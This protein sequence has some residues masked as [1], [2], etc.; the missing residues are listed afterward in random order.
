MTYK[1]EKKLI[2]LLKYSPLIFIFLIFIT[3]S[4]F[5]YSQNKKNFEDDK[6]VLEEN[7]INSNKKNIKNDV[8][9]IHSYINK[10]QKETENELKINLQQRVY[11]AYNIALSI[12]NLNKKRPKEEIKKMIKDA[13]V[14]IRFLDGRGYFYIYSF[15][16]ECILLPVNRSMEGSNFYY[17]KEGKGKYLT[18]EIIKSLQNKKESFLKWWYHKPNDMKNQYEKIGFNKSFE[19]F[20]WYIGT[21]EYIDDFE[22]KQQNKVLDYI[23]KL[24]YKKDYI[25]VIN[26][27]AHYLSHP[28]KKYINKD[29]KTVNNVEKDSID[30]II[31]EAKKS[32]KG[33]ITYKQ[34]I[35]FDNKK[36]LTKTSYFE[37]IPKWDWIIGKGFYRS[38]IEKQ[39]KIRKDFLDDQFNENIQT[40]FV[41]LFFIMLI[42]LGLSLYLSKHFE[43][44]FKKYKNSI[45]KYINEK[46]KQQKNIAFQA[47]TTALAEMLVNI[48]HQWRQ[49]LSIISTIST[50]MQVQKQLDC[51][52]D[53]DLIRNLDT[54]NNT[55]QQLSKTI[56]EFNTLFKSQDIIST[57]SSNE[58]LEKCF[59]IVKFDKQI[60][61]KTSID[62][63]TLS[64]YKSDLIQVL[65]NIFRNSK[66][67]F[68]ES[69]I[70]NKILDIKM[71]NKDENLEITIVDNALGIS[72]KTLSRVFEPYFTTKYKQQGKGNGLFVCK[73]LVENSLKGTIEIKSIKNFVEVKVIIPKNIKE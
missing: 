15:D 45:Q 14:N 47:K 8:E 3:I 21:G 54:I 7:F 37:Y 23:S 6:K 25:F 61:I 35:R 51:L 1:D 13:L 60:L 41:I 58:L 10:I 12:Y 33:Y 70:N 30:F 59:N 72:K 43:E 20:N 67:A 16:Y 56:D 4:L 66:E 18:R 26:S 34:K 64:S 46:T 32:S 42:F 73:N 17:F 27:K 24:Q 49:P 55:T 5:L 68:S 57:F 50:S 2:N 40:L 62:S 22:K 53:K 28:I 48:S 63:I 29:I 31:N 52:D 38:D 65:I 69:I 11:E 36:N 39:L 9:H 19:P 44:I 71:K